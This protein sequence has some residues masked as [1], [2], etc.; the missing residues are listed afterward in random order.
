MWHKSCACCI[1]WQMMFA[2]TAFSF[3]LNVQSAE[4]SDVQLTLYG[5]KGAVLM[6]T[7]LGGRAESGRP[8]FG[9]K[10]KGVIKPTW[11]DADASIAKPQIRLSEC[12]PTL[13]VMLAWISRLANYKYKWKLCIKQP[14]HSLS[15]IGSKWHFEAAENPGSRSL[16][17]STS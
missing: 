14:I 5:N 13:T 8:Q 1:T 15:I 9:G 2:Q 7:F 12:G 6:H 4:T 16:C 10:W 17:V 3:T 11:S